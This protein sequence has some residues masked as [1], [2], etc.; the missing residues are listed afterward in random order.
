MILYTKLCFVAQRESVTPARVCVINLLQRLYTTTAIGEK[1][2][3]HETDVIKKPKRP[4]NSYLRFSAS[5]YPN[6]KEKYPEKPSKDIMKEI[7]AAWSSADNAVKQTYQKEYESEMQVYR[8]QL[9]KYKSLIQQQSPESTNPEKP[10]KPRNAFLL[11]K[12]SRQSEHTTSNV[13]YK[14]WMH[15]IGRDWRNLPE[16]EKRLFEKQAD[17]LKESFEEEMGIWKQKIQSTGDD[18]A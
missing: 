10:K 9:E 16:E 1:K 8:E 18:R 4:L 15:Q 13:S 11:Y 3:A 7:A 2:G 12:Q 5:R 14:E 17:Q 6:L